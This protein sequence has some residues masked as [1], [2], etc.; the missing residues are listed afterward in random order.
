MH[1]AKRIVYPTLTYTFPTDFQIRYSPTGF[2]NI[3]A[4][5]V[6]LPGLD[7]GIDQFGSGRGQS[8]NG[9]ISIEGWFEGDTPSALQDLLDAAGQLADLGIG[10]LY[11][12]PEVGAERF[13]FARLN[14]ESWSQNVRDVPHRRQRVQ[15]NFQVAQARLYSDAGYWPP[16]WDGTYDWDGTI[17]WGENAYV[18]DASGVS[19]EDTLTIS[20]NAEALPMVSILP[21]STDSIENPRIQRVVDGQVVDE[22]AYG[23]VLSDTDELFVDGGRQYSQ[24][25]GVSTWKPDVTF[26][27]RALFRLAPGANLIRILAENAGDAARVRIWYLDTWR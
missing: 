25:N 22:I 21:E 10:R 16:F 1:I 24:L 14:A 17:S 13:C 4:Q 12:Q 15:F 26:K 7:G 3:A 20:G 11:I 8:A 19:T 2:R 18:I 5:L 6:K 9:D 27:H 23:G